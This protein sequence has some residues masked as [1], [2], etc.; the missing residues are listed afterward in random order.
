MIKEVYLFILMMVRIVVRVV[1]N[2]SLIITKYSVDL[3]VWVAR[4][5]FAVALGYLIY[6]GGLFLLFMWPAVIEFFF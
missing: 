2:S 3:T 5:I 1:F 6:W 4:F